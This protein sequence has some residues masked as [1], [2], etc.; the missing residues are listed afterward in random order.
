MTSSPV[1]HL[2]DGDSLGGF[3]VASGHKSKMFAIIWTGCESK[4]K[5]L[6]LAV[7]SVAWLRSQSLLSSLWKG[8]KH[9]HV[10]T[11]NLMC[12]V[13]V[14][15]WGNIPSSF[16]HL[17]LTV[18]FFALLCSYH[19]QSGRSYSLTVWFTSVLGSGLGCVSDTL[20][21]SLRHS[22]FTDFLGGNG[23]TDGIEVYLSGAAL[24]ITQVK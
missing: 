14:P 11:Q 19:P 8:C 15:L 2:S 5:C 6:Q 24:F 16:L 23:V 1:L 7:E 18:L 12:S 4:A 20:L 9:M 3:R 21:F 17:S 10:D 13:L 22:S